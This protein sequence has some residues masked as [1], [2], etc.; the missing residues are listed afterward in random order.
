MEGEAHLMCEPG[1]YNHADNTWAPSGPEERA[2]TITCAIYA[3]D[4]YQVME[5]P[6]ERCEETHGTDCMCRYVLDPECRPCAV[7]D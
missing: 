2:N 1:V 5:T 6:W 4:G 3:S 7:D